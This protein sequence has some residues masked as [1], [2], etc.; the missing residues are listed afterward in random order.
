MET[1]IKNTGLRDVVVAATKVSHVDGEK[2]RLFY[3]GYAIQD[4]AAHSTYEETAYLLLH[5]DLPTRE[6]L[7]RFA[8]ELVG[9]RSIPEP[10]VAMMRSRPRRANA[11]NVLMA[12]VP[13]LVDSDP[14]PGRDDPEANG[15]RAAGLTAKIATLT[16]AW[17]RIR[18]G[19]DPVAPDPKLPHAANFLY[20]LTGRRPDPQDA[21]VMD[22]CMVLYADH[23]FN[24]S[25]FAARVVAST[26]ANL[27]AAVTGALG[28]LSGDLHGGAIEGV[29][30]MLEEVGTPDRAEAY[31]RGL[32]DSGKK[33][34]GLGHAVYQVDDPRA[35]ILRRES[36]ALAKRKGD[37]KWYELSLRV[38]EVAKAEFLR[39][40]GR[41]FPVNVD[42]WS[43][44]VHTYLGIPPDL[45]TAV[46]ATCRI[47][48]W[49]A[50]TLEE[51]FA[52]AQP[53]PELYRPDAEYTGRWCGAEGCRYV[54][55]QERGKTTVSPRSPR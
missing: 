37:P 8:G 39:R 19:R 34:M 44:S 50:H 29:R 33:V 41:E 15:R 32:L 52:Q 1:S 46:F 10:V 48:G 30:R 42:Y 49:C 22:K 5:D 20:M 28:A 14:E 47:A 51:K 23:G 9:Q 26:R 27:H 38:Q 13:M 21:Q 24:A 2:G 53:K 16:A 4:L 31:I 6:Q 55:L 40:R 54:P 17:E 3:R 35:L 18:N 7:D 36:E 43:S 45:F 12:S 11:M 25:T